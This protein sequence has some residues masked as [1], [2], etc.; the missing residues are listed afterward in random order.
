MPTESD[1]L[2]LQKTPVPPPPISLL[3]EQ[4]TLTH[5]KT[6]YEALASC[7]ADKKDFLDVYYPPTTP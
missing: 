6:M 5:F 7:N 1:R 2:L 4:V 3:D